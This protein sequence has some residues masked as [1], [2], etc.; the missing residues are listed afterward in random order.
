MVQRLIFENKLDVG[1]DNVYDLI[2]STTDEGS[3]VG[4]KN[5]FIAVTVTN[6]NEAAMTNVVLSRRCL[7]SKARWEEVWPLNEGGCPLQLVC[8][9]A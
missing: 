4:T 5:Q 9:V 8:K 2:V 3:P 1:A 6:A 7:R